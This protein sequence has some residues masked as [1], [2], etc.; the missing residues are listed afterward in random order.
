MV[1]DTPVLRLPGQQVRFVCQGAGARRARGSVSPALI[2]F[3]VALPRED[4]ETVVFERL[5][6]QAMS[7][8]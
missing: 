3:F 7:F 4:P 2:P 1:F 5:S 8:E 6:L